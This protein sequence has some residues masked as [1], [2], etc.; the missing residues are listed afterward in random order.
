MRASEGKNRE[1]KNKQTNKKQED[2]TT[3]IIRKIEQK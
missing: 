2:I 1:R 3:R